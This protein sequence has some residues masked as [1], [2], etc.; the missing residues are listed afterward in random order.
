MQTKIK[1]Q[2]QPLELINSSEFQSMPA[3]AVAEFE[4]DDDS[5]DHITFITAASNLRAICYGIPPVDAMETRKVAGKIVP[6]MITTT[7]LVSALSCIELVKL[8]T[9]EMTLQR[10]RNAFINLALPFFAFTAPLPAE[11]YLGFRGATHTMWDRITIKEG[12]KAAASGGLTLKKLLKR[13][14]KKT[15]KDDPDAVSVSNI[16]FGAFMI[17]ASFL[18]EDDEEMLRRSI[19]NIIEE[20][21]VKGNEFDQE[22]SRDCKEGAGEN[23]QSDVSTSLPLFVDLTIAVEDVETGEEVELPP[24]RLVRT[25]LEE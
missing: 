12:K 11:E 10:H 25:L 8:C 9:A 20:A 16:S 21:A 6:A 22:F 7:A 3:L 19:W 17:Y 2:L 5:N 1:R 24:V 13:I 18:H 23:A 15:Y 4:K 14:R